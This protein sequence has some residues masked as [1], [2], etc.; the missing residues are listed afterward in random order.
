MALKPMNCPGHCQ[1]FGLQ[2]WSYRDLPVRY[3]EPGP[4]APQRAVRARCTA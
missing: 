3:S 1:L 4:A 2:Q